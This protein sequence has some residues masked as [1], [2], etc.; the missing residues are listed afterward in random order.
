MKLKEKLAAAF[1]SKFYHPAL[2]LSKQEFEDVFIAG[3][4]EAREM[5]I[6]A[7]EHFNQDRV[8][9]YTNCNDLIVSSLILLGE[10]EV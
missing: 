8:L 1:S 6:E 2:V 10:E 7:V 4:E 3:F 5:S 9:D